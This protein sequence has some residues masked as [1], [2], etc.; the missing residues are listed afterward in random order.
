MEIK[1]KT[2]TEKILSVLQIISWISFIGASIILG[3]VIIA[4]II[5]FIWP[6]AKINFNGI[7]ANQSAF[8]Q[9][10]LF[11]YFIIFIFTM[12]WSILNV[13]VWAKVK[14]V[15]YEVNLKNPFT[16]HI[17]NL[18]ERISL[19][20]FGIWLFS[21]SINGLTDYLSKRMEGLEKGFDTDLSF[22]FAAG[23]VFIISQIFKRGVELQSEN[24][25]TV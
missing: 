6:E 16:M 12:A 20:L 9:N 1:M 19:L 10:H 3:L 23:I 17:S 5:S 21:F 25:L 15:L 7:A 8:R 18:I 4:F 22:L 24:D 11:V 13:L 2:Q 14:K